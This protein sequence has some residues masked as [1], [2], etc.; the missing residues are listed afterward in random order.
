MNILI[1]HPT[2]NAITMKVTWLRLFRLSV[3]CV[4]LAVLE[5]LLLLGTPVTPDQANQAANHFFARRFPKESASRLANK[6]VKSQ[7]TTNT[8]AVTNAS[9]LTIGYATEYAPAGY[10]LLRAD[11]L[12]PPVKL[13]S[14][15]GAYSSLPPGFRKVVELELEE[16]LQAVA[17]TN[18]QLSA[19]SSALAKSDY[20]AEWASLGQESGTTSEAAQAAGT[21]LLA[22]TWNQDS[23]YNYY[24]PVAADGPGGRAYAGCVAAA[25]AMILHYHQQPSVVL[26]D[27]TYTDS[28]GTCRGTHRISDAGMSGYRWSDM[29]QNITDASPLAQKQA[30][31]QLMY[32]CGVAVDMD[33]GG[34]STSGSGIT[35]LSLVPDALRNYFNYTSSQCLFK[36]DYSAAQWFSRIK[37]DIDSNKPIFWAMTG[38]NAGHAVVCDGYRGT[39]EI[40]LNLGWSGHFNDWYNQDSAISVSGLTFTRYWAVFEI[41]PNVVT[42]QLTTLSIASSG[43]SGSVS[44]S[45]TPADTTGQGSGTAPF[46]RQ[47]N[48]G[49]T[50][51]LTAPQT[52]AGS[53]FSYWQ[54]T[55][56]NVAS[57]NISITLNANQTCTAVYSS[58]TPPANDNF[59]SA[60]TLDLTG[61]PGSAS[62]TTTAASVESGEPSHA[63]QGPYRSVWWKLLPQAD[64]TLNLD[65]HGSAF[66]T[67]LALYQGTTLDSLTAVASN[68]NDGSS[69]NCSGLTNLTIASGQT[70][71]VAVAGASAADAGTAKLNWSFQPNGDEYCTSDINGDGTCY[72]WP[73]GNIS[74]PF[75]GGTG[76]VQVIKLSGTGAGMLA[77]FIDDNY[78]TTGPVTWATP[79][80]GGSPPVTGSVTARVSPNTSYDAR[81]C[82]LKVALPGDNNIII[83]GGGGIWQEGRP[84]RPDFVVDS[85]SLVPTNPAPGDVVGVEVRVRNAGMLAGDAGAC[86]I[87]LDSATAP[88]MFVDV[89]TLDT[90]EIRTAFL[91]FDAPAV[92]THVLHV[93]VDSLNGTQ[94]ENESN[95]VANVTF[96]VQIVP[97]SIAVAA[98]NQTVVVGTAASFSVSA[99][100]TEPLVYRWRCNGTNLSNG[101]QVSGA[102]NSTLT[103]TNV[104]MTNA[105]NY[106][107]VVTN[108][109]GSV[110]SAVATLT[111]TPPPVLPSI[112]AQPQ[113]R[114]NVAGTTATFSVTASGTAPLSYQWRKN[115]TD[116]GNGGTV[117]G[118][119][120]AMLALTGV[121]ASDAVGYSVVVGNAAGSITSA[122]ANLTVLV[123]PAITLQPQN[124]AVVVGATASFNVSATGTT[125]LACQWQFNTSNLG[126]QT[127]TT[128]TLAN[129]Q[130]T[131]AGSY[132]VVVTNLAGSATSAVAVL[133]VNPA[134]VAPS[135]TAQPQSRTNVAGTTATFTVVA[136][137][138]APLA[139]QWR[140]NGTPLANGGIVSG[141]T[142]ANLTL[143]GVLAA[144]AANYTVVV[145]NTAG[146][147]TSL[148]A[149]LTVLLPP[150]I[151]VQPQSRTNIQGGT[152][153]FTVSAAGTAPLACQWRK[154]DAPLA[155]GGSVFGAG[156]ATLTLTNLQAGDAGSYT[157]VITNAVGS[158]TSAV[159]SLT[160]ILPPVIIA[161]PQSQ[162]NWVG[163]TATFNVTATGTA[164]LSYQWRCNGGNLVG[165]T[166]STLTLNNVQLTNAGSYQAVVTNA[167]GSVTSVV[168][169]LVVNVPTASLNVTASPSGGGAVT[170]GGTFAVGSQPQISATAYSGWRFAQWQDGNTQTPRTVTVPAEGASYVAQFAA[171][172]SVTISSV[173][174]WPGTGGRDARSVFKIGNYVHL[175]DGVNAV[176]ILNVATPSSITRLSSYNGSISGGPVFPDVWVVGT[177][178]YTFPVVS[179]TL[180]FVATDVSSPSSPVRL[181]I[182]I[183]TGGC[184]RLCVTNNM[185]YVVGSGYLKLINVTTPSSPS[186]LGSFTTPGQAHGIKVAGSY[187]YVADGSNGLTVVNVSTPSAPVLAGQCDTS[188]EAKDVFLQGRYAYLADGAAGLQI[189]DVNSPAAPVLVGT[190]DTPGD[191]KGIWVSGSYACVADGATGVQVIDVSDPVNPFLTATYD[192]SGTANGV[193]GESNYVYVADGANGLVILRLDKQTFAPQITSPPLSVTNLPGT[194]ATFAVST[195]GSAPF[196]YQWRKNGANLANGGNVSGAVT[197]TLTLASVQAADA[198][199]YTVVVTN[200]AGSVTSAVAS[201][202]VLA[203]PSITAQPQSRTN[204]VGTSA[205]FSV[206]ATG[207]APLACQWRCNS[208]NLAGQTNNTLTLANVQPSNAGNYSVVVTN[209]AGSVTSAVAL[210]AVQVAASLPE[211]LDATG[212][213]WTNGGGANWYP[214][215]IYTHD[216]VDAAQSGAIGDS[217]QSWLETTVTGPGTLAFWWKVS[218]ENNADYDSLRFLMDGVE[219]VRIFGETDWQEKTFAIATNT[220]TLR[221]L[222]FKDRTGVSGL[223]AGWLDQVRFTTT[224]NL[225]FETQHGFLTASNGLFRMRAIG[226]N[227][228]TV[229]WDASTN[230]ASWQPWRTNLLTNG[231]LDLQVPL[232]TNRQQFYRLRMP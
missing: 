168:A 164:P 26:Q 133:T 135:L 90:N 79:I 129:A 87:T 41:A 9:G 125:P 106:Q 33:F 148:V 39:S 218:C 92:G 210:L 159:A 141:A 4:I 138:T 119:D 116:L 17:S 73:D 155:D 198:A 80:A 108:I 113:S 104:Q 152:T 100:G 6:A 83:F 62:V 179:G 150:S 228:A 5:P 71:F 52:V 128:L 102:T 77:S 205:S 103:L 69:G 126:G 118:A 226:T 124:Q 161:Q 230:L 178:A 20:P 13:Y 23:P 199:S 21:V 127:N 35:D 50:V 117:S 86:S 44:I 170:G 66:N 98:D 18:A 222:Y 91:R 12:C 27:H 188:G 196:S 25:M 187:A 65:T 105:G 123:P 231:F 184:E 186:S 24:A 142:N 120:T 29:P 30:I 93:A 216:G 59:A 214:Q 157:V 15:D 110:T 60:A 206:T 36:G 76:V 40:H 112:T 109:A 217:Q 48:S 55:G 101:G 208:G 223:D 132:R 95:N 203:P 88:S 121:Q 64:G 202:T 190:C 225:R 122:V 81:Y 219:Q 145:T 163:S 185:A 19:L 194:T 97:P 74:M 78:W 82:W 167:A 42:P 47:Y 37:A 212:L 28:A 224:P 156:T 166:S 174:V 213:L 191:A 94:E 171:L 84:R 43:A 139:Y 1:L 215:T 229:V 158:L 151:T 149:S 173:G 143:A 183:L 232:G 140:K 181:S 72:L 195:A 130:F 165:Q 169:S 207:S 63:G 51:Y 7:T 221:W 14:V 114:T 61:L 10:V 56:G 58:A 68:D 16:E 70:Y 34:K 2:S 67:V 11:T 144:D 211:A 45:V 177:V 131:N 193:C 209:P 189:I 192:T 180:E 200:A 31:A 137:G 175:A 54:T 172:P 22:D 49:T 46:T 57:L 53:T 75:G 115:G 38:T 162:T 96:A 176:Q 153:V 227:Y 99:T 201:L 204:L 160:V 134:P 111:V 182:R 136:A 3:L 89:G 147:V 85:V 32:H 220:H 8:L 154:D 146:S 197:A 107:V